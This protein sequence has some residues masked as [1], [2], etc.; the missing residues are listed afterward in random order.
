MGGVAGA[1]LCADAVHD[2][3]SRRA[4]HIAI[5]AVSAGLIL[6]S[7][8]CDAEAGRVSAFGWSL[9]IRCQTRDILGI[10][11]ALCGMSRSFCSLGRGNFAASI[12]YH[13]V[14][15]ALFAVLFLQIPYRLYALFARPAAVRDGLA[16]AHRLLVTVVAVALAANWLLYLGGLVS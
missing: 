10:R 4:F 11:C 3:A 1:A 8:L 7:F 5:L 14:G 16:R 2:D 13:A 6:A 9:P 15:P 12:R